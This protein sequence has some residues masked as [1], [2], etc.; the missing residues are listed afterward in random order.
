LAVSRRW[1][2]SGLCACGVTHLPISSADW[3]LCDDKCSNICVM[4]RVCAS[5]S[6]DWQ[7]KTEV[8]EKKQSVEVLST[9]EADKNC[10]LCYALNGITRIHGLK[11]L[12]S[13]DLSPFKN[14]FNEHLVSYVIGSNNPTARQ[15]DFGTSR[16]SDEEKLTRLDVVK[17]KL[18]PICNYIKGSRDA[19]KNDEEDETH[20]ISPGTRN[21]CNL[22]KSRNILILMRN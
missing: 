6:L 10:K 3:S 13:R 15:W 14:D 4:T 19:I 9:E 5:Y 20:A 11:A 22:G 21:G 17:D 7:V 16:G 2:G 8:P 18:K 12:L 1:T